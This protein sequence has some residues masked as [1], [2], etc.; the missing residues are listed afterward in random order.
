MVMRRITCAPRARPAPSR[1]PPPRASPRDVLRLRRWLDAVADADP[2]LRP[3]DPVGERRPPGRG[4]A[5]WITQPRPRRLHCAKLPDPLVQH[6]ATN[7][8][9][10][11]LLVAGEDEPAARVLADNVDTTDHGSST[12]AGG[13]GRSGASCAPRPAGG[14][15]GRRAGP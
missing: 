7:E 1:R 9:T 4:W 12:G 11:V 10:G 15:Q 2:I 5:W 3:P 8:R 14:R 13:G 6:V